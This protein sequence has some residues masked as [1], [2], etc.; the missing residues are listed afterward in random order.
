MKRRLFGHAALATLAAGSFVPTVRGQAALRIKDVYEVG[1]TVYVRALTVEPRRAALWVGTS[2]GVHE[3]D[4]ASGKLRNTFTRKEGLANEYVFAVGLD[5]DGNK[6]F[7]TNAG[8]VSRYKDG[9]WKTFFPMHGLADYWV[10]AFA[11]QRNGDFWI[12]TWAG[13]NRVDA[14]TGAFSTYVKELVNEWVYGIAVDSFDRLWFGTEGGVSMYDGK[15]W[16]AWTHK[17]GLGAPNGDKLPFSANTGLGTRSRH[18]LSVGTE[19]PA[20]YNP[21]YVFSML[22]PKDGSI[23]AGTW[24]GGAARFDGKAWRNFTADDGLAGNIVYS[25]AQADDG[26]LWFGTNEGA[27][28]YDGKRWTRLG[29][30]EGLLEQHVYAI[31][32]APDGDMWI[33]TRK[34]VAR[35]GR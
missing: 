23:W 8:G 19:G 31:A 5:R 11:Q 9:R 32:A 2:A 12:G 27:S 16:V 35:I 15:R 34:G 33:G 6:W 10:Y 3:V 25:M 21:N 28:R 22:A 29:P 14:K 18:D 1:P 13:V 24:G 7:G 4:L 17:D 26:A 30:K 20:T